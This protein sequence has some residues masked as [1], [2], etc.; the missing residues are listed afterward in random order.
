M[1]LEML[2][3]NMLYGVAGSIVT[4]TALCLKDKYIL[5]RRT[6]NMNSIKVN[7]VDKPKILSVEPSTRTVFYDIGHHARFAHDSKEENFAKEGRDILYYDVFSVSE[8]IYLDIE[9]E[10]SERLARQINRHRHMAIVQKSTRYNDYINK[11]EIVLYKPH[12]NVDEEKIR[13]Q[14]LENIEIMKEQEK[15]SV[16]LELIN[17]RLSLDTITKVRYHVNLRTLIHMYNVRSC[18]QALPEFNQFLEILKSEIGELST[19]WKDIAVN[20]LVPHCIAHKYSCW[21][22]DVKDCKFKHYV[23]KGLKKETK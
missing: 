17:Y 8:Q 3:N 7:F 5:K 16:P 2:F 11:E 20:F 21:Y 4:I 9:C 15:A 12:P 19:D 6:N 14:T 10:I 23:D 13:K 18:R 22:P 1:M